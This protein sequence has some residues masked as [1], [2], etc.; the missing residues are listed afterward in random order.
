MNLILLGPPGS[1]KGTQARL[2]QERHGL[3]Q[4]ST[5]DMLRAAIVAGTDIGKQADVVIKSGKLVSDGI[6]DGIV[7]E[8]LSQPDAAKGFVL[9]GY[10]RTLVQADSLDALL[11]SRGKKL[12]AVIE[13]RLDND[14][15]L[16]RRVSGRYT[17]AKCGEGY[18]D[19]EKVPAKA[20]TCDAC[21][22]TQFKRRPDDNAD[23]VR[24]RLMAYYKE[25]SPLIGYYHLAGKR[26]VVDGMAPIDAVSQ[27][28]A[29]LLK[30]LT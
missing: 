22:G 20:G 13:L 30:K 15:E 10:P 23:T 4:L 3:V 1:G 24:T 25:T 9:D 16:I 17:C 21:G 12:D 26:H 7:A 18:H 11:K 2:L 19:T 5:G 8:R 27:A 14:E 6:V 29:A 28:L